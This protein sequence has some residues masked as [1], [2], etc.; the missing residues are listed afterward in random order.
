MRPGS[1]SIRR[2]S[3][4]TRDEA[5]ECRRGSP[6]CSGRGRYYVQG[7][8]MRRRHFSLAGV[9]QQPLS[10][11]SLT[12]AS[13][14]I[15]DARE[16]SGFRYGAR[17]TGRRMPRIGRNWP[18]KGGVMLK[19]AFSV[20]AVRK[21]SLKRVVPSDPKG[22]TLARVRLEE[23]HAHGPGNHKKM[24]IIQYSINIDKFTV[25]FDKFLKNGREEIK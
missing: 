16:I 4:P 1:P 2:A 14:R 12:H 25:F 20:R 13:P 7:R 17:G 21:Q 11:S 10:R 19:T 24:K 5:Q 22:E 9:F 3:A 6:P 23:G 15:C 18:V 8:R